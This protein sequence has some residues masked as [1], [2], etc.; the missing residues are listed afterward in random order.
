MSQTTLPQYDLEAL[1]SPLIALLDEHRDLFIRWM[2]IHRLLLDSEPVPPERIAAHLGLTEDE[3][4]DLLKGAELD[5]DGNLV[6]VGLSVVPTPHRYRVHGRQLYAWCAGDAITFPILHQANVEIESPDP[7]SGEKIR[8]TSTPDGVR[9]LDPFTAVVSWVPGKAED[10]E[11]VRA[12]YCNHI[13]FFT[14]VESASQYA[15]RRPGLVTI[16]VEHAFRIGQLLW[17]REPYQSMAGELAILWDR[18]VE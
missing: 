15:A 13:H 2:K 4:A 16:P 9:D 1:A 12:F 14:S 8:L 3:V 6:G 11:E 7:V 18:D 5:R 17:E 10:I